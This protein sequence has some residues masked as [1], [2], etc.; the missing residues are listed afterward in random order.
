MFCF[1]PK[2]ET[3]TKHLNN[4]IYK[5]AETSSAM[6]TIQNDIIGM[7]YEKKCDL[8]LGQFMGCCLRM[9]CGKHVKESCIHWVLR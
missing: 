2:K 8:F 7:K 1:Q 4:K 9:D 5:L 6:T 3:L